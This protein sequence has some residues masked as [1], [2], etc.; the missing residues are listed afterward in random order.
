MCSHYDTIDASLC[1]C[2]SSFE[3]TLAMNYKRG[4]FINALEDSIREF[5]TSFLRKVCTYF[6]S[7]LH[8][9]P[10]TTEVLLDRGANTSAGPFLTSGD[11]FF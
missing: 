3:K 6:E 11:V 9:L 8:L 2:D 10:I 7:E 5:E 1:V 4:G